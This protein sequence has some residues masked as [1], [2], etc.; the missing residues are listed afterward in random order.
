MERNKMEK[1]FSEKLNER[2]IQ[3]SAAAWDRLDAMLTVAEQKKSKR[4]FTWLY[5]AA[6]FLGF[7]LI[8]TIFFRQDNKSIP[9]NNNVVAKESA[10]ATSKHNA[11]VIDTVISKQPQ[12]QVAES[13]QPQQQKVVSAKS[14]PIQKATI[15]NTIPQYQKQLAENSVINQNQNQNQ[16]QRERNAA[17]ITNQQRDTPNPV[18]QSDNKAENLLAIVKLKTE[19]AP[20]PAVKV[21][22]KSLLAEVD[23][24]TSELSLRQKFIRTVGK[25]YQSVKVAVANR[26]VEE[27]H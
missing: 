24:S 4:S 27:N 17:A 12:Q 8:G 22:A 23:G 16:S 9:N 26:N 1:E 18:V 11:T 14:N 10:A 2:E 21:S 19:A 15:V 20:K 5:I 3:P 6:S 7:I 25:N 13:A